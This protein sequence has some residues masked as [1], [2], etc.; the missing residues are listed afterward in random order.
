MI[1]DN[2]I[3]EGGII[4][5]LIALFA[6]V[7][8]KKDIQQNNQNDLLV[9]NLIESNKSKDEDI[10]TLITEL[11]EISGEF[12]ECMKLMTEE[13]KSAKQDLAEIKELIKNGN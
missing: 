8:H 3:K 1:D 2:I 4:A 9:Q 12:K 13:L 11:K 5:I 7:F 6:K 10:K